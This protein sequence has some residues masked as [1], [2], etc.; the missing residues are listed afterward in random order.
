MKRRIIVTNDGSN[1]IYVEDLDETYHSMN[2]AIVE[3][4]HVFVEAGLLECAK[5][6][7]K[8]SIFE[9]GFGTGLNALLTSL[10][11]KELGLEVCYFGIEAFPVEDEILGAIEYSNNLEANAD[12]EFLQIHAVKWNELVKINDCFSLQKIHSK[13]EDYVVKENSIDLIYFDAFGPRA[14]KEMWDVNILQK[15]YN[16][17]AENGI[18]VTYCANGQFKRDLKSLGFRIEA[19]AGPPGK[20]EMTRA[21]KD[22]FTF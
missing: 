13:I 6:K 11:A 1:T 10:K 20:R 7:S 14:Q 2:G 22:S 3:A 19:L 5:S 4:N 21:M 17:L 9:M 15:M 18:L 8:I 16:M 12:N